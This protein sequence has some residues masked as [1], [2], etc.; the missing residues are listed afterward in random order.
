MEQAYLI[1]VSLVVGGSL[2]FFTAVMMMGAKVADAND[3]IFRDEVKRRMEEIENGTV[4]PVP[5]KP[6]EL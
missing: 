1:I 3:I 6:E 5:V 2:G 4:K